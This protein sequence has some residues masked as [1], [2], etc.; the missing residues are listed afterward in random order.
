[1]PPPLEFEAFGATLSEQATV[2]LP[3]D[4]LATIRADTL[5][6]GYQRGYEQAQA[7]F[8]Q[9]QAQTARMLAESLQEVTF[10]HV[11]ARRSVLDSLEPLIAAMVDKILPAIADNALGAIV[12][13]QVA[14]LAALV[15]DGPIR[16]F[17]APENQ[18]VL[19]DML[20]ALDDLPFAATVAPD[21][22]C[23]P[24]QVRLAA[25]DGA[26]DIDL[27]RVI[28]EIR[29]AAGSFYQLA[30]QERENG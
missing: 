13:E 2:F 17:C 4:R 23:G 6:A 19:Q 16:V 29:S 10:T 26:R 7:E 1:M 3:G 30:A 20:A 9:A 21:R 28:D 22:D 18:G 11:A 25:P 27:D 5:K 24:R 15:T 12:T 14:A 8:S